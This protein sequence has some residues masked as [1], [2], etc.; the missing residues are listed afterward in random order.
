MGKHEEN[1]IDLEVESPLISCLL[2]TP[3]PIR[4]QVFAPDASRTQPS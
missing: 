1:V 3:I 2:A 4:L